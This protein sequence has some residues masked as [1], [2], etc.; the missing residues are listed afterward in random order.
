MRLVLL[1]A[2]VVLLGCSLNTPVRASDRPNVLIVTVDDMSCDSIGVFGCPV[3]ETT[4][5][6]DAF[7]KTA[8]RFTK[9][10]VLV[11]NCMPGRNLMWSGLYSHVNG[12]EGFRQNPEPDYPVLCDLAKDAG[13]FTAIRGKVNHSTPYTPYAWD[14]VLDTDADG[15]KYGVKDVESYGKSTRDAI[16]LSKQSG[17]PFCLMV[18]ISD[19]HKPFYSQGFKEG[20]S[21]PNVPS[22]V[23]TADEVVVPGFLFD[24]PVVRDELALYYSS[25]RR[26][27]DCFATV[28][29]ALQ[30]EGAA[31]ETMVM[32]L[33]DHGMPLPFAKT[34]LYH[35]STHTPLMVRWPGKT[36]PGSIDDQHM[37]SAIDFLPTLIDVM[38]MSHPTSDRLH[39]QSFAPALTG[40]S[41]DG[42][43]YVIK[44]Y[45]ENSGRWRQPMRGIQTSQW[46]Y[47]YNPWSDGKRI[48]S[49]ATNG[50]NTARRMA[51]LARSNPNIQR[52]HDIYQH[53]TVEELYFVSN[54][55]DCRVNLLEHPTADRAK[56]QQTV[57]KLREQL[58]MELE[59]IHDPVAPLVRDVENAQL[60]QQYMQRQD[61][62]GD[63][64][65]GKKRKRANQKKSSTKA[66]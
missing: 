16:R 64:L 47:L 40:Q 13:Y 14:A 1:C 23:F 37:V 18:N 58:A 31:E 41:V 51:V 39:G 63:Q 28:M 12:V 61:Q 36:E 6:I 19:P 45:N 53:R 30:Q 62:F 42:F 57:D 56:V 60:R 59:R 65:R 66:G 50:T 17:K 10:H 43:G 34:Q 9:A 8:L 4:P 22:K 29:D 21:D 27:D 25:V 2:T 46:L 33:S 49:T 44:Q 52:R 7:A 32:F 15:K 35:H 5:A 26:A 55:P 3:P 54:D 38:G 48:F 20:K 11:G 24:D